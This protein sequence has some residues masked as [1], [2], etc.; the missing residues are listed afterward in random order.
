MCQPGFIGGEIGVF[1]ENGTPFPS[2]ASMVFEGDI[3]GIHLSCVARLH[4]IT[5]L[6]LLVMLCGLC[7][8]ICI[9]EITVCSDKFPI[10]HL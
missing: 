3:F 9:K 5:R 2:L 1:Y 7:T 8:N 4:F 10:F 6:Q